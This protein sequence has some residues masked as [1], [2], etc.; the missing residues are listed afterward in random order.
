[1]AISL[2]HGKKLISSLHDVLH[3]QILY[4]NTQHVTVQEQN[5][6][7]ELLIEHI[8]MTFKPE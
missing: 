8:L 3:T 5:T 4:K 2:E 7:V 1:M 6:L